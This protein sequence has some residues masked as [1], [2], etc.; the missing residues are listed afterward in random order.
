MTRALPLLAALVACRVPEPSVGYELTVVQSSGTRLPSR[1]GDPMTVEVALRR[2]LDG[3][4]I[5][6]CGADDLDDSPYGCEASFDAT[7]QVVDG[8][9]S[10]VGLE[11]LVDV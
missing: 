6:L 8:S 9:G 4:P 3:E 1:S 7:P 11:A 5:P 2:T 10:P